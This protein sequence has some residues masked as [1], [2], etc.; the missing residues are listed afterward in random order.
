MEVGDGVAII[1]PN[2]AFSIGHH[3][4]WRELMQSAVGHATV[5]VV[6]SQVPLESARSRRRWYRAILRNRDAHA[7]SDW[8]FM[9]G[10]DALLALA[11]NPRLLPPRSV[12]LH[13]LIFRVDPQPGLKGR[14]AWGA[15]A[16]ARGLIALFH[17]NTYFY[18]LLLPTRKPAPQDRS[19][20]VCIL[21]SSHLEVRPQRGR[22]AAR[23]RL[24]LELSRRIFLVI[25]MIGRGKHVDSIVEGWQAGHPQDAVLLIV[26]ETDIELTALLSRAAIA[27]PSI[28]WI[29]KRV[30]DSDFDDYIESAD[31]VLALYRYSASSGV[32]LRSLALGTP[33]LHGGSRTLA[34]GLAGYPGTFL[35]RRVSPSTVSSAL[36]GIRP[37]E[38]PPSPP[39]CP[40]TLV[41]PTP[42]VER[43][44]AS[45]EDERRQ[46]EG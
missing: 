41:F 38:H 45:I 43:L 34:R 1:D 10:D 21:D 28:C 30:S 25:G 6:S 16:M 23:T 26:G 39:N 24:G 20:T 8:V 36:M 44:Q 46:E 3:R 19:R 22:S 33:V 42:I 14:I 4:H 18:P 15:R 11:S 35:L 2:S 37:A 27:D 40:A 32:V 17:R 13:F 31:L 12:R 5:H 29:N 9:S 7:S